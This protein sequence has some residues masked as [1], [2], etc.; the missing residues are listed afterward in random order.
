MLV[1]RRYRTFLDAMTDAINH[2]DDS[3]QTYF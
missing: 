3:A 1:C 2:M